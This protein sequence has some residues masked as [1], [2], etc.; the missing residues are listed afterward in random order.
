MIMLTKVVNNNKPEQRTKSMH[1]LFSICL[2]FVCSFS[3]YVCVINLKLNGG[4]SGVSRSKSG[5]VMPLY[6]IYTYI[7]R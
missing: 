3:I 7:Q 4:V 2:R 6:F 1:I 5:E